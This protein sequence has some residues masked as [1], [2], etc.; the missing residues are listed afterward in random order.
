[1][2]RH[3]NWS[4]AIVKVIFNFIIAV[5]LVS[6]SFTQISRNTVILSHPLIPMLAQW[7]ENVQIKERLLCA[8]L[9][10]YSGFDQF[11]NSN[12]LAE[13]YYDAQNVFQ[14]L[15]AYTGE[16]TWLS[17]AAAAERIYSREFTPTTMFWTASPDKTA[18]KDFVRVIGISLQQ[19]KA[20]QFG[21]GSDVPGCRTLR[22]RR[23]DDITV[24]RGGIWLVWQSETEFTASATIR[25]K[26]RRA[27]S[28][29][30]LFFQ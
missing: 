25:H 22:R 7:E 12:G 9:Q 10:N 18:M 17:C 19:I 1:M 16:S 11:G 29:G 23:S 14:R 15:A 20:F 21:F 27:C 8:R 24:Y 5:V 26:L 28:G 3:K 30:F 13:T 4:F 2:I 6:P